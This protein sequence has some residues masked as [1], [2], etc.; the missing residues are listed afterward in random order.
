MRS[1][2]KECGGGSICGHGR[3]RARCKECGGGSICEHGRVR[4][5]CKECGGGSICEHGRKRNYCMLCDP[6]GAIAASLRNRMRAAIKG[7]LKNDSAVKLLGCSIEDF[8]RYLEGKFEEGM[9]LENYGE[10]HI[11]H[12]RPCSSFDLSDEQE[13]SIC[14]HYTNLQ[15]MWASE[16]LRKQATFDEDSF[17]WEWDGSKWVEKK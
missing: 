8:L 9:T 3:V 12:R 16:N 10:W 15:P 11:D 1:S 7:N 17:D 13:Q 5:V 14:F 4:S 6:N 2:C